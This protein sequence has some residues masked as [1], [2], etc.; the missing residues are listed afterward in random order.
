MRALS[1]ITDFF[2][3]ASGSNPRQLS[4]VI[5][6]TQQEMARRGERPIGVEG[7]DESGWVLLDY[8]DVVVH[9]FD[10]ERRKL[11][12]LELLWGDSPRIDWQADDPRPKA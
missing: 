12:D 4:A 5:S 3:I 8:G 2:V 6:A 11:Y 1:Y 10:L 9:V 7:K